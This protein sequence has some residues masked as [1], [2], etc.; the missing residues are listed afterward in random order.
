MQVEYTSLT[1]RGK[2][3]TRNYQFS[4]LSARLFIGALKKEIYELTNL[5]YFTYLLVNEL[6]GN[7]KKEYLR[8]A[9]GLAPFLSEPALCEKLAFT[10]SVNLEEFFENYCFGACEMGCP[11]KPDEA[12]TST[13]KI[14]AIQSG[15][16]EKYC[17]NKLQCL[18]SDI[19]NYIL[20]DS[21]VDFF[22]YE[23]NKIY[24]EKDTVIVELAGFLLNRVISFILHEG[25]NLLVNFR[26][27]SDKIFE[28]MIHLEGNLSLSE[29]LTGDDED[30]TGLELKVSHLES[31]NRGF[32]KEYLTQYPWVFELKVI[33]YLESFCLEKPG[34]DSPQKITWATLDEFLTSRLIYRMGAFIDPD[35]V[36]MKKIVRN[37]VKKIQYEFSANLLY[38]KTDC[39]NQAFSK[40]QV[41]L[42][43]MKSYYAGISIFS[44]LAGDN[45]KAVRNIRSVFQMTGRPGEQ[46]C[47][48]DIRSDKEYKIRIESGIIS[49]LLEPGMYLDC[50]LYQESEH[51]C[52][53]SIDALFPESAGVYLK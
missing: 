11:V 13:F 31:F 35:T 21:L 27:A 51:W 9:G 22:K 24:S 12:V 36:L 30:F 17:Q 52:L 18:Q 25:Q 16:S 45:I 38:D 37:W 20:I 33:H 28:E 46:I 10:I 6:A 47:L 15:G 14:L 42:D 8:P 19:L 41:M 26:L 48:R 4:H 49:A 53:V 3:L 2:S 29:N 43:K 44:I 39:L 34:L 1:R 23:A 40:Y 50:C 7:L 32:E 5:D